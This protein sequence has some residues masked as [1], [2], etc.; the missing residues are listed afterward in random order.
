MINSKRM[1]LRT[2][3]KDCGKIANFSG[4][5]KKFCVEINFF[6]FLI[7]M[8]FCSAHMS[9]FLTIALSLLFC[10][11]CATSRAPVDLPKITTPKEG[12]ILVFV[13]GNSMCNGWIWLPDTATLK[14]VEDMVTF[15]P[16][17]VSRHVSIV[18]AEGNK[19]VKMDYRM[20]K[21]T[22][23]EKRAIKLQHGD[24]IH[25]AYDRCFGQVQDRE[26]TQD[27]IGG[28][29]S[30]D[31]SRLSF[32]PANFGEYFLFALSVFSGTES[33]MPTYNYASPAPG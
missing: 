14:T 3:R 12:K 2:E 23:G 8:Q 25:F 10:A 29:L 32:A 31:E 9:R 6:T 18:N 28:I 26:W 21:M 17:W 20:D 27:G 1:K 15:R 11:G 4:K 30:G 24:R 33:L 22:D 16:E 5:R 13:G 19:K 7:L